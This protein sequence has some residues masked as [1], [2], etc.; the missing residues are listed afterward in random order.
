MSMLLTQMP[1]IGIYKACW[2]NCLFVRQCTIALLKFFSDAIRASRVA[3]NN[4]ISVRAIGFILIGHQTSSKNIYRALLINYCKLA[5]Q[6]CSFISNDIVFA[7]LVEGITWY[8][9]PFICPYYKKSVAFLSVKI[10][11]SIFLYLIKVFQNHLQLDFW[12]LHQGSL[13]SHT[14]VNIP[15]SYILWK[16]K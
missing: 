5:D 1:M 4:D 3:S 7:G 16:Q 11:V 12:Y 13:F 9:M 8:V 15:K 10:S 6:R 14:F 2:L